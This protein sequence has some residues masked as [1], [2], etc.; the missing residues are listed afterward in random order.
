MQKMKK[1]NG[2]TFNSIM[3]NLLCVVVVC[4]FTLLFISWIASI[5]HRQNLNQICRK[6]ILQMESTGYLTAE[7]QAS[8]ISE[9]KNAGMVTV[10]THWNEANG[11][12]GKQV[13]YGEEVNLKVTGELEIV[14]YSQ[15]AWQCTGDNHE[16][17]YISSGTCPHCGA[18]APNGSFGTNFIGLISGT[19]TWKV[20]I[21]KSSISKRPVGEKV[22]VGQCF[23]YVDG[24]IGGTIKGNISNKNGA[25]GTYTTIPKGTNR[26]ITVDQ[27]LNIQV[28][29]AAGYT[30]KSISIDGKEQPISNP[31]TT[32]IFH[33]TYKEGGRSFVVSFAPNLVTYKVE[34]YQMKV[35]GSGYDLAST[36]ELLGHVGDLVTPDVMEYTGF[37][38][39]SLISKSLTVNSAGVCETVIKYYYQ[40]SR[41]SFTVVPDPNVSTSGTSSN[42]TY[43]Y[44]ATITLNAT[45]SGKPA[46]AF[47]LTH[48]SDVNTGKKYDLSTTFQMPANDVKI[49]PEV[50]VRTYNIVFDANGGSGRVDNILGLGYFETAQLPD[51]TAFTKKGYKVIGWSTNP[52]AATP[53][54]DLGQSVSELTT[55]NE[56][57]LYAVWE[58]LGET[59]YTVE[60]YLEKEDGTYEQSTAHTKVVDKDVYATTFVL[61]ND[62][63]VKTSL[64]DSG[65]YRYSHAT[66]E[67][68]NTITSFYPLPDGSTVIKLYYSRPMYNI[69]ITTDSHST[70]K[71]LTS[72]TETYRHGQNIEIYGINY[73][74]HYEFSKWTEVTNT[75][76]KLTAIPGGVSLKMPDKDITIHLTSK[77][78][79][80]KIDYILQGGVFENTDVRTSYNIETGTFTIENPVRTHYTFIGWTGIGISE[81]TTTLSIVSGEWAQYG[82]LQLIANWLIDSFKVI[83]KNPGPGGSIYLNNELVNFDNAETYEVKF[84]YDTDIEFTII[85]IKF[86]SI[87]SSILYTSSS[88][89]MDNFDYA[90][91]NIIV[92]KPTTNSVTTKDLK[93][94]SNM[95]LET[96]F[97]NE[98]Y[99]IKFHSNNGKNET[100]TQTATFN[101]NF[102][103]MKNTFTR[104]GYEFKGWS[105]QAITVENSES[106]VEYLDE[107]E[108]KNLINEAGGTFD[109]Y[110]VWQDETNPSGTISI[111][112][113][114]ATSQMVTIKA[115]DNG[116]GVK[117]IIVATN[118]IIGNINEGSFYNSN[119][120]NYE[121]TSNGTYYFYVQDNKGN[122]SRIYPE[123]ETN[124]GVTFHKS[125]L[126]NFRNTY[127]ESVP[128][129]ITADLP[130]YTFTFPVVSLEDYEY[131][132]WANSL[133]AETGVKILKPNTSDTYY[134]IFKPV[135]TYLVT[136][137]AF[138]TSIKQLINDNNSYKAIDTFITDIVLTDVAP[139]EGTKYVKLNADGADVLGYLDGTTL[140]LYTTAKIIYTNSDSSYMFYNLRNV[141]SNNF[142][143]SEKFNTERTIAMHWMFAHYGYET[144]SLDLSRFNTANVS[145]MEKMFAYCGYNKLTSINFGNNFNTQYVNNMSEMFLA[146]GYNNLKELVINFNTNQL[147]DVEGM[148]AYCGYKNMSTLK[149]LINTSGVFSFN[150]MFAYTGCENMTNLV[151]G[152]DF[153]NRDM[154][155]ANEMFLYCGNGK[156]TH[157]DISMLDFVNF[158]ET[159]N[160]FE[161]CGMKNNCTIK[162]DSEFTVEALKEYYHF[163]NVNPDLFTY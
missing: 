134:P 137:I 12:T 53:T 92:G 51:G 36:Q 70:I 133:E 7:Q 31:T 136:G 75:N 98:E 5:E 94:H 114:F 40:R 157:L 155:S 148:F 126:G 38:T 116:S 33:L 154:T 128:Y 77:P 34:H 23:I 62:E 112:N 8:L 86:G 103:L 107:Q 159:N 17:M 158:L 50:N 151:L 99:I 13:N 58:S 139:S 24:N 91:Q 55:G 3:P 49:K 102:N 68:N 101:Q 149:V 81:A 132:G 140:K 142:I 84:D 73:S 69:T 110:A 156:L 57:K 113:D 109:L 63:F 29:P 37:E 45:V 46:E 25:I 119:E 121:I 9:L 130:G 20:D 47:N 56:I 153:V 4:V 2:D 111:T 123:G 41:Y 74:A 32:Q 22:E 96:K 122:I 1:D 10:D 79:E 35:N 147:Q 93:V 54:Y 78:T 127:D 76:T 150:Y 87:E 60:Y 6:Y 162:F 95:R 14:D 161:N 141:K 67:E 160:I 125:T 97:I 118:D 66:N 135:N 152:A 143:T 39:P 108:V 131:T 124:P 16:P 44:G 21:E 42:G 28:T 11:T 83:I 163:N 82:D 105:R 30:I 71:G 61:I 64:T 48:W 90:T 115:S 104:T 138:N 15:K 120:L 100:K 89:E 59:K 80:Y 18:K 85:P 27:T 145:N 144:P 52:D 26:V 129:V 88:D 106:Y 19:T 72:Y 65:D 146:F 117:A 43:Y